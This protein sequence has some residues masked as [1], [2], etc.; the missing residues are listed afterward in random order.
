MKKKG[1]IVPELSL[2]NM[3]EQYHDFI[4]EKTQLE[5]VCEQLDV[6]ALITTKYQCDF[7]GDG[8]EY[9]WA[10]SKAIYCRLPLKLKRG[11]GNFDGLVAKGTS[12]EVKKEVIR[13][14]V[15]V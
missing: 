7:A 12:R 14:S 9:S 6:K 13:R 15:I 3:L 2:Y 10:F 5:Y 11:K 1:D 8:I 4:H